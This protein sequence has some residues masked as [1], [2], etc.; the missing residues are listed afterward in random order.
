MPPDSPV[1]GDGSRRPRGRPPTHGLTVLRRA[2]R[3]LGT[4]KLDQRSAIAIAVKK[5]KAEI[6]ADF[7]VDLTQAQRTLLV[8]HFMLIDRSREEKS[9]RGLYITPADAAAIRQRLPEY[10]RDLFAFAYDNG[11]RRG[12]LS[13][14]LRRYVDLDR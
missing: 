13:R 2:V 3:A 10:V 14:T 4:R 1:E 5:W 7:V 6:T 9:P 12:Q 11:I 8:G